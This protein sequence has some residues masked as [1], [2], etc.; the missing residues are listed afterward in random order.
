[1]TAAATLTDLVA[2]LREDPAHAAVL[3]D[4]DGTLAPIVRHAEDAAV[5]EATRALLIDVGRRYGLVACV[6]GR[7]A[8][9]ARRIV[10]IGS[11]AYVGSHGGELLRPGAAGPEIAPE[12]VEWSRR[13]REFALEEETTQV[14]RARLRLEDKGPIWGFHWRGAPDEDIAHAAAVEIAT[15][16]EQEGLHVHWGRKV[17]EIRPPVPVDK[18]QG[19]RSL[20]NG[21]TMTTA[22]YCGDDNT[23]LDA[24]RAMDELVE[25][26]TLQCAIRVGVR[27]E[28]GPS[29]IVERADAV[30]DGPGEVRDLLR[31][32][33]KD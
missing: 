29:A 9:T 18:G 25:E 30:L 33:L 4:I 17:L 16:A 28:E 6:T 1:V 12:L 3:L 11:L 32:L 10:S 14:R 23:D 20:L 21:S 27:S 8:T 7:R 22:L 2:P 24:F 5:P 15:H 26:G 19:V 31:A 13:V